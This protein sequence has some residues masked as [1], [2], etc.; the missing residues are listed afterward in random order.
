MKSY[1]ESK[2][3]NRIIGNNLMHEH[4]HP[5]YEG[6]F[7]MAD[8]FFNTMRN[9]KFISGNWQEKNIKLSS[10]YSSNWGFTPLDSMYAFLAVASLKGGWPFKKIQ[11]PNIALL[12]F[13]PANK[14]DSV[15]SFIL[16][17]HQSTLEMGHIEL[18]NYYG[19]RGELELAFRE[20]NALIYTVP[21]LDLFY[22]PAVKTLMQMKN[23]SKALEVLYEMLRYQQIPFAF[24]WIGQ[25]YLVNNETPKG[26]TFLEK[27]I[28]IGSQDLALLFNLGRAYYKTS[29]FKKGDEILNQLKNKS[30]QSDFIPNLEEFRKISVENFQK[31]SEYIKKA[32][33]DLKI[34]D[35]KK[36]YT[37]LQNSLQIQE[38][39][40]AYELIGMIDLISGSKLESLGNLEKAYAISNEKNPVLL[41]NLSNAYYVNAEY[42]KSKQI[43]ERLKKSY[44]NFSDPVNLERKLLEVNKSQIN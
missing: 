31:A 15:A 22:E 39:P 19:N 29:Q 43:F 35:F 44:P 34:K 8:A 6:Y 3:P 24:Q 33:G 27:A 16:T 40:S 42:D 30:A 28:E 32:Q 20:Y 7:L 18:A 23:Y 38:T 26:I 17:T 37:S 5:N 14:I 10:Y 25:I 2:S 9:E 21:Y 41:Y 36:A 11:G 4:L 12:N 13:K 1:F